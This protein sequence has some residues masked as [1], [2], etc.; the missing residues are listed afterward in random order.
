MIPLKDLNPRSGFPT[1]T[2]SLIVVNTLIFLF[3]LSL[4]PNG[5][6]FVVTYGM[7]PARLKLYMA[8]GD[9][10]FLSA[11][12]PLFTSM[13]LHGGW[14]H[15]IGNMWFLWIFGGS[16]EEQFGHASYLLF[17]LICGLVAGMAQVAFTFASDLPGIGASG[18]IAGVLG[19][20]LLLFP[21]AKILTLMTFV[22]YF[23]RV[24]LPAVVL[25]AYGFSRS[26]GARRCRCT[27]E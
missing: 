5:H 3:Q 24:E 14:A 1:V 6:Q 17:Y 11:T 4:G 12:L 7:V 2:L 8:G 23:G 25:S 13:F 9:E 15:L 20:Y 27:R 26:S 10:Q 18:A 16:V 19:A 21:R 22:V